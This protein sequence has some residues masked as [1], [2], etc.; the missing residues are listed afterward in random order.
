MKNRIRIA[1]VCVLLVLTLLAACR[2]NE[3]AQMLETYTGP[4]PTAV[5]TEAP[6]ALPTPVFATTVP[7]KPEDE[8]RVVLTPSPTPDA[9]LP[10]APTPRP[11]EAPTPAPTE[12]PVTAPIITL[13]GGENLR[14]EAGF[15]FSDP[16]FFA[17][18]YL[19]RDLSDR[20]KVSGEVTPYLV[21]TYR[22]TYSVTDDDGR[23]TKVVRT[24]EVVPV[25]MP[26][27]VMPPEKTVYLT[28]DDGPCG[29]TEQ[30]LDV[31][32]KYDAKATFFIVGDR[33]H[34]ETIKRAYE[35]G[36]TI[37]VHCYTHEYKT[38][39]KNEQ[40]FFEDF[41]KTQEIIKE[42]TGSYTRIF[43][44]PGGSANTASRRNKGIMTRLT[45]IMEDMGYRY[46]DW[47]VSAGDSSG[48]SYTSSDVKNR[49]V[50][51]I[52]TH[53]DYAVVLQHDIHYQSVRAV[54]SILKWGKENGYTFRALDLT[55]PVIHSKV[56]N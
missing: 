11:T 25:E 33:G 37:G 13:I 5:P 17:D 1:A 46:F 6:T 43:R 54:E 55:S 19:R 41:L 56:Q 23:N 2:P 12:I 42:Q 7:E 9:T 21:G 28:F 39:Y 30:L 8:D 26:E 35:E 22:I 36:H 38:I 51:G 44:F 47:N 27:I 29:Y 34:A 48:K 3:N 40:A 32:K 18:D 49:V 53:S 4:A 50:N 14:V 52:R 31:L 45:K 10:P 16:G 24:V 15:T 20:V